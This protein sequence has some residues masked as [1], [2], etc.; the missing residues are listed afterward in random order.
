M[1]WNKYN[2]LTKLLLKLSAPLIQGCRTTSNP[3]ALRCMKKRWT[4]FNPNTQKMTSSTDPN[5]LQ[6]IRWRSVSQHP[7]VIKQLFLSHSH[8]I[9]HPWASTDSNY[10]SI[11]WTMF[12]TTSHWETRKKPDN[13]LVNLIAERYVAT[14]VHKIRVMDY[15]LNTHSHLY[16]SKWHWA[17]LSS[18]QQKITFSDKVLWRLLP[19][20][21]S[22]RERLWF[23][24]KT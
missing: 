17:M 12:S 4:Q 5:V 2:K 9:S 10:L 22:V 14:Q 13:R 6:S 8:F 21:K 11:L 20:L 18:V 23:M 15:F 1:G 16:I 3:L 7:S 24:L 19:T